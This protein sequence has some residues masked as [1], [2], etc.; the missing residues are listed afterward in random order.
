[1]RHVHHSTYYRDRD[2]EYDLCNDFP[3][4]EILIDGLHSMQSHFWNNNIGVDIPVVRVMNTAHF[5]AAYMFANECSGDRMEYDAL[6]HDSIGRNKSLVYVTII[7]LAAML[8][9]TNSFR[10]RQCRNIILDN[11]DADFEE[12]VTLYERFLKSAEKNFAEEDFLID[13]NTLVAKVREKDEQIAQLSSENIQLK[14]TI[15]T[16]EEKYQQINIGT[17][18]NNCTINN[19]YGYCPPSSSAEQQEPSSSVASECHSDNALFCRITKTAFEKGVAQ[20][21]EDKLKSACVSAPKLVKELNLNDALGYTDTKD[22]YSS[23]LF[24]MLDEHYGLPF[25]KHAFT[26]ARSK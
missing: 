17:Q 7:V 10:A 11:R 20:Q 16:M 23:D 21:V 15:T 22:L 18:N 14:Y 3:G 26:V 25:K 19:Y 1:M 8:Q 12:G 6:A 4:D 13:V 2:S 5:L 24:D 9:R